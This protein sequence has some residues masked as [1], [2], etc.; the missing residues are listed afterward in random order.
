MKDN[1]AAVHV[2][3][4]VE[5]T[6]FLLNEKRTEIT[7][8]ELKQRVTVLLVPNKNLETPNY[9]LERLRHDDPR[10]ENLQASYTMVDEQEEEV[11]ITRREKTKAKQE[12]VI[13]GILPETPAPQPSPKAEATRDLSPASKPSPSV[14]VPVSAPV[15][16]AS[17]PAVAGGGF[18][19]W[20]KKIFGGESASAQVAAALPIPVGIKPADTRDGRGDQE[21]RGGRG[22]QEG[23]G[24][25][26]GRGGRD[27]KR[28]EGRGDRP[29]ETRGESRAEGNRGEGRGRR[30]DRN[31]DRPAGENPLRTE[32]SAAA[33]HDERNPR[34]PRDDNRG[35]IRTERA[36][37]GA[38]GERGTERSD[39]RRGSRG[40]R[41]PQRPASLAES[42]AGEPQRAVAAEAFVDTLPGA[43]APDAG[44]AQGE[45]QGGRRRN[46]RG[47]R[48]GRDRDEAVAVGA[49]GGAEVVPTVA[50][51]A[52]PAATATTSTTE[53]DETASQAGGDVEAAR[54]EGD[55]P[56]ETRRRGRG[57]DRN[58]RE[59]N[60]EAIT[61]TQAAE[62]QGLTQGGA[63]AV[64][65]FHETEPSEQ[66][67]TTSPTESPFDTSRDGSPRAVAAAAYVQ[68]VEAPASLVAASPSVVAS[69]HV[70]VV[71]PAV[72]P[73]TAPFV[74]PLDSLQAV[75]E[76][77]GLQW[78]NSDREKID[79][80]QA[81]MASELAPVR[82]QRDRKPATAIDTGPLVLV[83]TR[84]DLSQIKLPFETAAGRV[85]EA[86]VPR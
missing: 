1:T 12:P 71:A 52:T 67:P 31:G 84:K 28:G 33:P 9:R 27:S 80:A 61:N 49:E 77:A 2:Q 44:E 42:A 78:I 39:G 64:A 85:T 19:S 82:V 22:D 70:A 58:R 50:G 32:G 53:P 4:P 25:R 66:V 72:A 62:P 46:R 40:E 37:E 69:R 7:K 81:A 30:P 57:R 56:G 68:P 79:A 55:E 29:T 14:V 45:R 65:A 83:E 86:D 35:E 48:G 73:A 16:G 18:F 23:R 5:V 15:L 8:I 41:E 47:G 26:G 59:R 34:P 11:G 60:P 36:S 24:G 17:A 54:A 20:V 10:L 76:S 21:G 74:L 3:V 6:S 38:R 75:A 13:K 63:L 43:D 51:N